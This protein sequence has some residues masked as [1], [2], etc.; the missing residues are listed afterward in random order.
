MFESRYDERRKIFLNR[1]EGEMRKSMN[2]R[3]MLKAFYLFFKPDKKR[4]PPQPLPQIQPDFTDFVKPNKNGNEKQLKY[5]WLGHSTFIIN[6][7]GKIILFDPVFHGAAPF[8]FML[9]R[10]QK[11]VVQAPELPRLDYIVL[12]HDHYDHLDGKVWRQLA[13][14]LLQRNIKIITAKKVGEHLQRYGVS[15]DKI[16]E[17]DWWQQFQDADF[18]FTA[19]PAQHFS[20]RSFFDRNKTLWC[21]FAVRS[22]HHNLYFSGDSGYDT[23]FKTIGEKFGPFDITFMENGQYNELWRAV[24]MLPEESAQAHLDVSGN[25]M[26]PIHWGVFKLSIHSWSDPI[27]QITRIARERNIKLMTPQIGQTV[28]IASENKFENWWALK[29]SK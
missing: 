24:H 5:I 25:F 14:Q 20:G 26:V 3:V 6:M 13:P 2:F 18:T 1:R 19:L 23:H 15:R 29:N 28:D 7:D 27:E 11:A 9:P 16:I 22:P 21:S 8:D 4:K 12:S 10:F 17:L